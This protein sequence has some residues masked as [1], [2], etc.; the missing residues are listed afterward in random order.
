MKGGYA[1]KKTVLLSLCFFG[2]AAVFCGTRALRRPEPDLSIPRTLPKR[3]E[4][5]S[6]RYSFRYHGHQVEVR[7]KVGKYSFDIKVDGKV[8]LPHREGKGDYRIISVV[9]PDFQATLVNLGGMFWISS[10]RAEL[11]IYPFWIDA[12]TGKEKKIRRGERWVYT[13]I[14][15]P[16]PKPDFQEEALPTIVKLAFVRE[17][18]RDYQFVQRSN[19]PDDLLEQVLDKFKELP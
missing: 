18:K 14:M 16:T 3:I 12:S 8:Y 7:R 9:R 15:E 1:V 5:L 2:I 6:Y 11:M 13:E 4:D 19:K 10:E 17:Q